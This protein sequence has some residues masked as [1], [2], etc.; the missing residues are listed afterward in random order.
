MFLMIDNFDSFTYN[1]VQYLQVAG[2]QVDVYSNNAAIN[3][4]DF[5]KYTGI[6]LSPGPSRPENAGITLDIIKE[7]QDIPMLGICLGMQSIGHVF[8]AKIIG[9]QQIMHGKVD[10]ISHDQSVIFQGI[11]S[12]FDAVRY[13]SLV[14][15]RKSLPEDFT[16]EAESSDG[17]IMAIKHRSKCIWGIQFHPE[18]YLT[19]SGMQM[20]KNFTGAAYDYHTHA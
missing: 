7:K 17:E 4:I 1:I 8:G 14:I 13:H 5:D 16:I 11:K 19:E 9:A 2:E 15:D 6:I 3:E 18:S 20:I 10:A 12:P